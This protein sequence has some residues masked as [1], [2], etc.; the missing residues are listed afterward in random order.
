MTLL[1]FILTL[2]PGCVAAGFV[3]ADAWKKRARMVDALL[4][5][6]E[7]AHG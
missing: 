1:L 5:R 7:A 2:S 4:G 3:F 6:K